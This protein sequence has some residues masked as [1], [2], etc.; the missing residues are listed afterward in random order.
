MDKPV[1]LRYRVIIHD[2]SAESLDISV[3]QSQYEKMYRGK[4]N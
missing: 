1:I 2:G 3:L 4:S